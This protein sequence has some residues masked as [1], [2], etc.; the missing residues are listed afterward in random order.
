MILRAAKIALLA[1]LPLFAIAN[2]PTA[3][4]SAKLMN[5]EGQEIGVATLTQGPSGVLMHLKVSNLTPGKHGLHFHSH[6]VC[7]SSDGFKSAKGHVGIVE[8]AHGLLNP[9]GPE[10]GDLPNLYVGSDGTGEMET[11]STLVSLIEGENNLLDENGS[12][13]IIHEAG[14]DHMTQPIGGAGSRVGCGIITS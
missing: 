8:G 9:I 10:P 2:E 14:D 1:S 7:E 4:A 12:T 6:G 5:A 3:T 13:I 11:F